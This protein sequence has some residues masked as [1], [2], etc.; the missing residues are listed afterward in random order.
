MVDAFVCHCK[1]KEEMQNRNR[2]F[3]VLRPGIFEIIP[4]EEYSEMADE[5]VRACR[6]SAG[7]RR[8]EWAKAHFSFAA[9]S[10]I[11]GLESGAN[12]RHGTAGCRFARPQ[13]RGN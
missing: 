5:F 12:S 4:Q 8:N 9:N 11:H 6:E 7:A 1:R 2:N 13:C 10:F 3:L